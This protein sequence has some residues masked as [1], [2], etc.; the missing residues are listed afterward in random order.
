MEGVIAGVDSGPAG[1]RLTLDP[2]DG[3]GERVV[4]IVPPGTEVLVERAD[5]TTVP[6][7]AADLTVGARI[8]ARHTGAEMRSL[9]PQYHA[10]EIRVLAGS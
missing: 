9:P 4:L 8:G 6:G 1:T 3:A 5:G 10:T 7:G 2:A